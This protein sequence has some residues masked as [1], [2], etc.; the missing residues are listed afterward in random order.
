[1]GFGSIAAPPVLSSSNSEKLVERILKENAR[2][3]WGARKVLQRLRKC[4]PDRDWP[5]RS[6]VFDI[7]EISS[8]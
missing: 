5:A 1:V 7:L 2:Y 3:G 8:D 4:F 6:T